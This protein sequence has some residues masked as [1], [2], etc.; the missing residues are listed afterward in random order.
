LHLPHHGVAAL[1]FLF[2]EQ[3][4]VAGPT[5]PKGQKPHASLNY[6]PFCTVC[7]IINA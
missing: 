1:L 2:Q 4:S 5:L 6:A 3:K 7:N